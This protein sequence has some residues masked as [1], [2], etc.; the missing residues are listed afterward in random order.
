[1]SIRYKSTRSPSSYSTLSFE[2]V[3]L[4]GLADDKGL[5]IPEVIPKLDEVAVEQ[6]TSIC[7]HYTT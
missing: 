2:Q 5:F 7:V 4:G 3:V 6:V 1:M